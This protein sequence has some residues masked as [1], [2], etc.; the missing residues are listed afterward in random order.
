MRGLTVE[1]IAD[2]PKVMTDG[3]WRLGVFIEEDESDEQ[4]EKLGGVF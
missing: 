1:E 2:K 3:D 4:A